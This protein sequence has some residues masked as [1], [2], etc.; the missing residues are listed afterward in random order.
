MDD[1]AR[2]DFWLVECDT[3]WHEL[4][5]DRVA[6][7][8]EDGPA[9]FLLAAKPEFDQEFWLVRTVPPVVDDGRVTDRVLVR[10]REPDR[11]KGSDWT[12]SCIAV[13]SVDPV[14]LEWI[15]GHKMT[16]TTTPDQYW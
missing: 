7:F 8:I 9:Q 4:G 15:A 16:A 14:T 10:S 2:P 1:T 11:I 13:V 3:F 6:C 5:V 12:S